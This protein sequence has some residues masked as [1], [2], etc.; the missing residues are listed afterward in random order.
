MAKH[1]GT[2]G[3][4]RTRDCS[5]GPPIPAAWRTRYLEHV[6][7]HGHYALAAQAAG[8]SQETARRERVANPAFDA[9]CRDARE[10]AA[11]RVEIKMLESAERSDN[12]AGF[13]VRLKALRPHEYIE[14]N[15]TV[16]MNMTA[17]VPGVDVV[18]VL[19]S[20][21]GHLTEPTRQLL[22]QGAP[23]LEEGRSDV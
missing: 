4:Q 11:D 17:E 22:A 14:K 9:D 2:V 21:L 6:R 12:P 7:Q 23:Q 19:Q 5:P 18:Q 10:E 13:I 3:A 16:S 1:P 15:V 8:I 20:M